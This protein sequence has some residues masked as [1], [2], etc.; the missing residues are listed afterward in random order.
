MPEVVDLVK[1]ENSNN[2]YMFYA[3]PNKFF[4]MIIKVFRCLFIRPLMKGR[5]D[6]DV[7]LFLLKKQETP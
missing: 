7:N 2:K 5:K 3:G 4:T 1:I 6:G